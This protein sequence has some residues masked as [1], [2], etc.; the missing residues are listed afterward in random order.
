MHGV[1]KAAALGVWTSAWRPL[2]HLETLSKGVYLMLMMLGSDRKVTTRVVVMAIA[3][4]LVPT[5]SLSSQGLASDA[6]EAAAAAVTI[7]Q[8]P[9]R[10]NSVGLVEGLVRLDTREL[11]RP[12]GVKQPPTERHDAAFLADLADALGVNASERTSVLR[13]PEGPGSCVL[14]GATMLITV[15]APRFDG[16]RAL[17]PVEITYQIELGRRSILRNGWEVILE[18]EDDRWRFL[19]FGTRWAT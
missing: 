13:C 14:D 5:G 3:F 6:V 1:V 19:R 12:D 16:D 9:L 17:V 15:G 4:T 2:P 18:R 11:G 8:E 10:Q 7:A